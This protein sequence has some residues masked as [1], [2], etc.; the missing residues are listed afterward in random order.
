MPPSDHR[1]LR[2]GTP[3]ELALAF[4]LG[5]ALSMVIVGGWPPDLGSI[6]AGI[7]FYVGGVIVTLA[8]VLIRARRR[9]RS[10][11]PPAS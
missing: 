7:A 5:G 1:Y 10:R 6:P 8:L 9:A 2:V 4:L 3:L 11:T